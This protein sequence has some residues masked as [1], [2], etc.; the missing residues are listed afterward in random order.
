MFTLP[1]VCFTL[2]LISMSGEIW[3]KKLLP[4]MQNWFIVASFHLTV[5]DRLIWGKWLMVC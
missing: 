4:K 1:E 5:L 2:C 3:E